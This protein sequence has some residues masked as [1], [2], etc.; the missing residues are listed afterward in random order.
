MSVEIL[1]AR[2]GQDEDNANGI[3]NGHRDTPLTTLGRQQADELAKGIKKI[4]YKF[5]TVYSSP[6]LRAQETA[7]II[8]EIA[9]LPAPKVLPD[10]I[11]RAYGEMT[12]KKVNDIEKLCA[13]DILKSE[14]V[15]WFLYPKGGESFEKLAKRATKILK[16]LRKKHLTGKIL[17]VCHGDVGK[18]IY[19]AATGKLWRDVL[20]GFH[21]GNGDLID[22]SSDETHKIKLKQYNH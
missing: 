7:R 8:S 12:G 9:G 3:L 17:L 11:E 16:S 4:N 19:A 6:L 1:I 13:P 2:H 21:F 10:I 22:I 20:L 14:V 5:D 18:M 15:T